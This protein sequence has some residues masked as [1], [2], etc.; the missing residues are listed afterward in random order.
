M[1]KFREAVRSVIPSLLV[2]AD[3]VNGV[4]ARLR[5][6]GIVSMKPEIRCRLEAISEQIAEVM[7]E[8][9]HLTEP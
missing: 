4:H 8:V 9:E 7:S 2:A 6:M 1:P 3:I 5:V